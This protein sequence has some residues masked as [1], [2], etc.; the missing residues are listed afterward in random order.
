M[1]RNPAT[2]SHPEGLLMSSKT[3][4]KHGRAEHN[5]VAHTEQGVVDTRPPADRMQVAVHELP[6][7]VDDG[8]TE[9]LD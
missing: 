8:T 1:V 7:D 5:G 2:S 3:T 4:E 9:L 6:D